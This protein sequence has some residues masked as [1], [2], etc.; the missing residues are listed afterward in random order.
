MSLV[1]LEILDPGIPNYEQSGWYMNVW[2]GW[3]AN[4]S[5]TDLHPVG[6]ENFE[7]VVIQPLFRLTPAL[8]TLHFDVKKGRGAVKGVDS[9]ID[10]GNTSSLVSPS[11]RGSIEGRRTV[12]AGVRPRDE[13]ACSPVV[14]GTSQAECGSEP[15]RTVG[16]RGDRLDRNND[17]AIGRRRKVHPVGVAGCEGKLAAQWT[18]WQRMMCLVPDV[19]GVTAA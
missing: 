17:L 18:D 1:G 9:P 19:D 16:A 2:R 6:P 12:R 3:A 15:N 7:R 14:E 11:G 8:R 4:N 10:R 13:D 5:L